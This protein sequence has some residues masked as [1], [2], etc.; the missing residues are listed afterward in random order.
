MQVSIIKLVLTIWSIGILVEYL[1]I[2]SMTF[3][4][5]AD[6]NQSEDDSN[7]NDVQGLP[8]EGKYSYDGKMKSF[9]VC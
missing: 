9:I 1:I 5:V 8:S 7:S 6:I 2:V 4:S 3:N